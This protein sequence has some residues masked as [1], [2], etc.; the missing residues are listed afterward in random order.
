M[1]TEVLQARWDKKTIS[2]SMLVIYVKKGII[3]KE[4]YKNITGSECK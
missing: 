1:K 2:K 3:T 4:D